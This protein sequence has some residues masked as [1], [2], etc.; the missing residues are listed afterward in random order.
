MWSGSQVRAREGEG[1]SS[2][3]NKAWLQPTK[4][5]D[6]GETVIRR[7]L[8]AHNPAV[9]NVLKRADAQG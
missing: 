9:I 6:V 3:I 4:G 7:L 1:D 5:R 8:D 2:Y